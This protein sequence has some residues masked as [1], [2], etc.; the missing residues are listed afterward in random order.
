MTGK[1]GLF[2]SVWLRAEPLNRGNVREERCI[3]THFRFL[4]LGK[5][6]KSSWQRE[7]VVKAV[8]VMVGQEE[9][10]AKMRLKVDIMIKDLPW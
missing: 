7:I 5:A 4:L 6:R 2:M 8:P 9:K 3:L 1:L 10:R